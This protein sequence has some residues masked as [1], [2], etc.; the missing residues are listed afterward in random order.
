MG[1]VDDGC[2]VEFKIL[3]GNGVVGSSKDEENAKKCDYTELRGGKAGKCRRIIPP[4][5]WIVPQRCRVRT[6]AT[7]APFLLYAM[8]G[9]SG[10]SIL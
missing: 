4:H 7:E 2:I 6:A 3:T 9:M 1:K 10:Q 8:V 5:P